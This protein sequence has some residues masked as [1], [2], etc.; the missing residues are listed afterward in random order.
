MVVQLKGSNNIVPVI[1]KMLSLNNDYMMA[2][3]VDEWASLAGVSTI[4]RVLVVFQGGV[5]MVL[6]TSINILLH[7][8]HVNQSCVN[9]W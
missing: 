4:K 2:R 3:V 1:V 5:R 8:I 6:L 9:W 7:G